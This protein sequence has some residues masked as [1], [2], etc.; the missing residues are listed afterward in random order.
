MQDKWLRLTGTT[1]G[2][3]YIRAGDIRRIDGDGRPD[4]P[5]PTSIA[6]SRDGQPDAAWVRESADDVF[7][8]A[9]LE[10]R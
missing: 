7:K 4:N 2:P 3:I 8:L 9:G 1:G 6:L 5:A 10:D